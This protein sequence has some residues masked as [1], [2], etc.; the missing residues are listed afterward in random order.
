MDVEP[1]AG[2][3]GKLTGSLEMDTSCN[4]DSDILVGCDELTVKMAAE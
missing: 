3:A 4:T 1:V 2:T